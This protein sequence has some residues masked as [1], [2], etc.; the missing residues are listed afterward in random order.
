MNAAPVRPKDAAGLIVVREGFRGLEILLGKRHPKSRFMPSVYVF[1]G[2]RMAPS[3]RRHSGFQEYFASP[4]DGLDQATSRSIATFARTA[5]RETFEETGML[6]GGQGGDRGPGS[7]ARAPDSSDPVWRAYRE[8]GMTPPFGH[9]RLVARAITPCY[10]PIRFHT[11]FF[12]IDCG[13]STLAAASDGELVDVHWAPLD[14]LEQLPMSSVTLLVLEEALAHRPG[15]MAARFAWAGPGDR[16]CFRR[17][18]LP[19]IT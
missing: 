4:P 5:L 17:E 8:A 13:Q 15:R 11:R 16:K 6:I 1:P 18:P 3:D 9:L 19:K 14:T 10:S 2:G 7:E 12:R